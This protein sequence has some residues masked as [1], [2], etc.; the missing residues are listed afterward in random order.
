MVVSLIQKAWHSQRWRKNVNFYWSELEDCSMRI[1]KFLIV[2][3]DLRIFNQSWP[4]DWYLLYTLYFLFLKKIFFSVR[5]L[6][7]LRSH[8]VFSSLLQR[9][10]TSDFKGFLYQILS[11]T[12]F[13]YLISWERA[14]I[15][16]FNVE[17]QTR[18]L[19]VPFLLRL[20]YD[21]VLD[22]GS[23]PGPPALEASTLPL[24]YRGG[25]IR[26]IHCFL[27]WGLATF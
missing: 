2:L 15:S 6:S 3:L 9:P 19:L 7:V 16:L 11:I 14:I 27:F 13:S 26:S 17:C 10:M 25:G 8:S 1:V 12:L 5:L 23:N 24:G 22:W 18:E 4:K 21:A 20:W